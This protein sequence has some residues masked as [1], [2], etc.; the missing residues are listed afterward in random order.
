MTATVPPPGFHLVEG[1]GGSFPPKTPSFPTKRKERKKK[2]REKGERER[3]RKGGREKGREG[4]G[5]T[6][7]HVY[8]F[9]G[10]NPKLSN[11]LENSTR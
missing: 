4:E 8:Y 1:L 2:K 6:C 11:P 10:A 9:F 3:E 7:M 5:S